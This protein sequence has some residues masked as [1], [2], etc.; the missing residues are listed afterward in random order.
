MLIDSSTDSSNI[1]EELFLVLYFDPHSQDGVSVVHV[2][3]R[4]FAV[5]QLTRGTGEG[6]YV[7]VKKTLAYMGIAPLEW[8]NKLIGLGCDGT[9]A[10]MGS[11]GGLKSYLQGDIPWLMVSWCLA[12]RLE[13][14]VKD[15][16]KG[17]FFKEIDEL[18]LQV[19][20][21]YEKSP[22][23]C[24]EL[25]EIVDNLKQCLTDT[26]MPKQGGTRPLRAC[27]TRFV[28]HKVAALGRL[29]DRYGAYLNHLTML[30]QD[31]T[32]KSVD[33]EKV[34]GYVLR[35]RKS[36]IL[37]GCAFFYDVLKPLGILSKILQEDE[38][39][40]VR[41][42]EAFFKTKKAL[43]EIKMKSFEDIPTVKKVLTRIQQKEVSVGSTT[44]TRTVHSYQGADLLLHPEALSYLKK[45]YKIWLSAIDKCLVN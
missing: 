30:S 10:N 13:L 38:L 23:K 31:R 8:K 20:Y 3:D 36:K 2:R 21:V 6:L 26:E 18:L 35:W 11:A 32:V 1:D 42:I 9:N 43:E 45:D 12:H 7:C 19:Y 29:I 22:K 25:K 16:L 14:S 44:T 27:G 41:A 24:H 34:K 5:R 17:T 4:F 37:L 33:R 28:A 39:C 40:L 15:A